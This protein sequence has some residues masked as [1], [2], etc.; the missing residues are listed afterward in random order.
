[1]AGAPALKPT[2]VGDAPAAPL[3]VS[4]VGESVRSVPP[5]LGAA[6]IAVALGALGIVMLFAYLIGARRRATALAAPMPALPQVLPEAERAVVLDNLRLW[7]EA[8]AAA[9]TVEQTK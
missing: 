1:V 4:N 5:T 8:P 3:P 7:L 2:G 9:R 6:A